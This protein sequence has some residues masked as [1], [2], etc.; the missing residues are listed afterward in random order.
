MGALMCEPCDLTVAA[1]ARAIVRGQWTSTEVVE[2][3]LARIA[4]LDGVLNS[5]AE[6]YADDA[7]ACARAADRA[8]RAGRSLGPFHGVPIALKDLLELEG[9]VTAGGSAH[10]R[11]RRSSV[12]AVVAQRL[13]DQGLI[14]LGKTQTVEFAYSGW[15]INEHLGTPWNPWDRTTARSPGGSSSGA[16]VATAARLTPW[17]V[18]TDTGGSVRVPASF[19]GLTGLKPTRGLVS[20]VGILPLS[21]SFDTP[22]PIARTAEDAGLLLHL[23]RDPYPGGAASGADFREVGPGLTRRGRPLK[24]ARMPEAEREGVSAE[25]LQAYDASLAVFAGLGARIVDVSLPVRFGDLFPTYLTIMQAEAFANYRDVVEDPAAPLDEAIRAG[26]LRGRDVSSYDYLMAFRRLEDL[27]RALLGALEGV[28]ALLT[29][30]T[31]YAAP[32]LVVID[33]DTAPTRFTRFV[34]ALG[35]CALALP[36]GAT[37][38]G[39]PLSVQIVCK[40]FCEAVA[41]RLGAA[42]QRVT[43]WHERVPCVE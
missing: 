8:I 35:L 38:T 14:V 25:V 41:L 20:S 19:C 40:P 23:M 28:D 9:C 11:H 5:F 34:N 2:A 30:T 36:G 27:R 42:F 29:P 1:L 17:A 32:P 43:T 7:R 3:Y 12:T 31:E 37:S 10:F 6:V 24:L 39:L 26:I 15:G 16:G 22:G 33:R 21:Q 13:I 4:T 18:G